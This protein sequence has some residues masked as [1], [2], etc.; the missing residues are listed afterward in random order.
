MERTAAEILDRDYL[1]IRH[2]ILD[3]AAALDRIDR[4]TS[5]ETLEDDRRL[6]EIRSALAV[7]AEGTA[8]RAERVQMTFSRLTIPPGAADGCRPSTFPRPR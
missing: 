5:R 7:L 1:N 3:I 4:G 6:E 8:G 2:R